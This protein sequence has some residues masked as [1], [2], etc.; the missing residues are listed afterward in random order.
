LE[1]ENKETS[2][3][4]GTRNN[5]IPNVL[6]KTPDIF[7]ESLAENAAREWLN[8]RSNIKTCHVY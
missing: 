6:R 1:F 5:I 4:K 8:L 3:S 2:N 7:F